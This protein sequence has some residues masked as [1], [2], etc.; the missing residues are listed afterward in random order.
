MSLD[1]SSAGVRINSIA[2]SVYLAREIFYEFQLGPISALMDNTKMPKH[3]RYFP[4]TV[5]TLIDQVLFWYCLG[6]IQVLFRY[7]PGIVQLL[8]NYCQGSGILKV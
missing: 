8:S 7:C 5:Q 3:W 1:L 2:W 6:I 4:D